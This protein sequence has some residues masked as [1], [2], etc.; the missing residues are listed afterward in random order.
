MK[1]WFTSDLHFNHTNLL[2]IGKGRPFSSIEEHD[3]TLIDNWNK[4]VDKGDL[5]YILG[6]ISINCEHDKLAD[7]FKRLNASKHLIL[8]NHD[9][10]KE[11]AFL[12]KDNLIQSMRN[13]HEI[14]YN[15]NE[16]VY[17]L[18]LNHYPILEFNGA[19]KTKPDL[20]YI[21]CYGHTH[22][23]NNYD[24]IYKKLG[25][26][27]YHVGVD[28]NNYTPVC[29]DSIIEKAEKQLIKFNKRKENKNG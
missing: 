9:R 29:I 21:H 5:V 17:K 1:I 2:K 8:G 3:E 16:K 22:G 20:T 14:K 11:V 7:Y 25:F 18:I 23:V 28:T 19:F 15:L 10:K 27:A 4:V 12:L 13:Y 6:D 26:L 24:K